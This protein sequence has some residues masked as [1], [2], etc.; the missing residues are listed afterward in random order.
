MG[1]WGNRKVRAIWFLR[2]SGSE[3]EVQTE[4]KR[5]LMKYAMLFL[6]DKLEEVFPDREEMTL[7][8]YIKL[9]DVKFGYQETMD[10]PRI[11]AELTIIENGAIEA[12]FMANIA[13]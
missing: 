8:D 12:V 1:F 9:M 10:G 11:D 4:M 2:H 5:K 6:A 3:Q 13:Q 7:D